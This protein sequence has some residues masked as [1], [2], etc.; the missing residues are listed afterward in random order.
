MTADDV[1]DELDVDD[2]DDIEF[3]EPMMPGSDDEFSDCD[4]DL[5]DERDDDEP[6]PPPSPQISPLHN[7]QPSS[8]TPTDWSTNLTPLTISNFTSPVGPTVPLPE[9]A[10]ELFELYFTPTSYML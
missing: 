8:P 1:L 2:H 5:E 6:P 9:T 3:D 7:H 4:F 10:T